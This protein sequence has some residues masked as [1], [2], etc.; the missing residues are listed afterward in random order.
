[1]KNFGNKVDSDATSAGVVVADEYNSV[2]NEIKGVVSPFMG[3]NAADNNQMVKSI[4]IASKAMFY[5][6][7][8]APNAVHLTRAASI[9][10]IESLVDGM[11][12]FFSPAHNNTGAVTLK[13]NGLVAKQTTFG[14][15]PLGAGT[16]IPGWKYT[17]VYLLA[18]DSFDIDV[19]ANATL[20]SNKVDKAYVDSQNEV[21]AFAARGN[22][23]VSIPGGGIWS[24]LPFTDVILNK[25]NGFTGSPGTSI[26]NAPKT[27][28]YYLQ[29]TA[30]FFPSTFAIH[31]GNPMWKKVGGNNSGGAFNMAQDEFN[32]LSD[33]AG[34]QVKKLHCN[35]VAYIE[36]DV[37][38]A[39][40]LSHDGLIS[41]DRVCRGHLI[42]CSG[43]YIGA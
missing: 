4:D 28:Y 10:H 39:P 29:L 5:S 12:V 14:G 36:K 42:T 34:A 18:T 17:A 25:G 15:V 2:F 19:L 13:L 6:D 27:G 41:V 37:N 21:I 24:G 35:G 43:F 16:L 38:I 22:G 23:D 11:T 3:L 33:Y 1:M 9:E 30:G 40:K 7:V 20:P 26:F 32:D 31:T 8:G